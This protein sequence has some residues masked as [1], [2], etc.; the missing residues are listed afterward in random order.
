LIS[1]ILKKAGADVV[2]CENGQVAVEAVF[3]SQERGGSFDLILMDMQMPV[4]D[5]YETTRHLRSQGYR[6]PIVALT[7]HAMAGDRQ[8]CLDAGCDEY[9]SK[10]VDRA[11]LLSLV[12]KSLRR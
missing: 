12:A 8:K 1:F 7:A 10:P 6:G 9:I 11:R 3:A 4:M 2:V 5:G